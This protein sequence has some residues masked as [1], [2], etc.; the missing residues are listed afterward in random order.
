MYIKLDPETIEGLGD[1]VEIFIDQEKV[2]A[3]DRW[4]GNL[5]R[6]GTYEDEKLNL[7]IRFKNDSGA[8]SVPEFYT[9]N[10][11]DLEQGNQRFKG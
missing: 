10:Y 1:K 6:L 3:L 7:R 11:S 9:L 2:D 8:V 4:L 5:V